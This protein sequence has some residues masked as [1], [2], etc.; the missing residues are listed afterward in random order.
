MWRRAIQFFLA[1]VGLTIALATRNWAASAL[2]A[3]ALVAYA[4]SLMGLYRT[5]GGEPLPWRYAHVPWLVPA[6]APFVFLSSFTRRKVEWRGRSYALR[7]GG[8]LARGGGSVR[9]SGLGAAP[10]ASSRVP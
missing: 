7:M 1:L 2:P 8:Q 6:I 3:L 4:F 9:S 5:F 10:A